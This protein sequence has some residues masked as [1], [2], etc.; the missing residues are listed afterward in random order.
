MAGAP[1]FQVVKPV[2]IIRGFR[3]SPGSPGRPIHWTVAWVRRNEALA[4]DGGCSA[5]CPHTE[6][7][8]RSAPTLGG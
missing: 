6:F 4:T 5:R 8:T 3:A 2:A 1:A 7:D